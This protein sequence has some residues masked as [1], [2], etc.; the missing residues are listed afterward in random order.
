MCKYE[1]KDNIDLIAATK[2]DIDKLMTF[3]GNVIDDMEDKSFFM[4]LTEQEFLD[5]IA[6]GK[7]YM[8]YHL[9][10]MMGLVVLN[11]K[12]RKDIIDEYKLDDVADVGIIDGVMIDK[13]YRGSKLQ[14]QL[15]HYLSY[16]IKKY[17]LRQVVATVNP[18]N[19]WSLNNFISCG[20]EII[21]KIIIHGGERLILSKYYK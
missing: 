21:N 6:I 8:L 5:A 14:Q 18:D 12:P 7:V 19:V 9:D 11:C 4:P 20:Y 3:Q 10:R 15:I 16:E 1:L 17:S 2:M 13:E